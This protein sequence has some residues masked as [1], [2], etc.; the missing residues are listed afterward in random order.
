[1]EALKAK[2]KNSPFFGPA[3][4]PL[5][6]F[7]KPGLS[8]TKQYLIS[9][10]AKLRRLFITLGRGI[11]L[12]TIMTR[13]FSLLTWQKVDFYQPLYNF[14]L[15]KQKKPQRLCIDRADAIHRQIEGW[16]QGGRILDIGCS[17]GYFSH[18]FAERGYKVT[19]VDYDKKNIDICTLLKR[20]NNNST[21]FSVSEFSEEFI[22]QI[23]PGQFDIVF[24]F[25]VIHHIIYYKGLDYAQNLMADILNKTSVM[26]IELAIKNEQLSIFWRDSLPE[27]ELAIFDKCTNLTITKVGYFPTHLSEV[28]R[29]LYRVEKNVLQVGNDRYNVKKQ[30][31]ISYD[32]GNYFGRHFY[33][34]GDKFIKKYLLSEECIDAELIEK[35]ISNY[36]QLPTSDFLPKFLSSQ[37]DNDSIV[38][39]FEK[40]PGE[41][42]YDLL[43]KNH[44]IPRLSIFLD[45][46]AALQ[47]MLEYGFYHNDLRTWNILFDGEKAH[48]IDLGLA[49]SR[50]GENTNLA[51][52]WIISQM[53]QF[54]CYDFQNPITVL[55]PINKN[56]LQPEFL[57]IVQ[58]L[59][60]EKSFAKFAEW[61]KS[62]ARQQA[63]PV[64]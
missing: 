30:K 9:F 1:M 63:S 22:H 48:V 58:K 59:E 33:D 39:I 28:R 44:A 8:L 24:I 64:S 7:I 37:R 21:N 14:P 54:E 47:F 51:L 35:E 26:F 15:F 62:R 60:E 27:D 49:C 3:V 56:I 40:I 29:P 32:G 4:R 12:V 57:T 16:G 42:L 6:S 11:E 43:S 25:S 20:V 52:L 2:I 10:R 18:Y 34:C 17:L 38:M 55:P 31:F 46:V 19:G 5:Y 61:L 45:I 41:N 23:K 13:L 36:K 53:H 50:E